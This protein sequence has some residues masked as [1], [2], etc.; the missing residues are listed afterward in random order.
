MVKDVNCPYCGESISVVV[1]EQEAGHQYIEDC[2]VC[3]RPIV[4]NIA[5]GGDG[6]LIVSVHNENETF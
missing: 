3:C 2:Q 1:D 6:A 5:V 4:F